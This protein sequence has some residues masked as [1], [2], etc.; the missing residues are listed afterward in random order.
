MDEEDDLSNYEET[1]LGPLQELLNQNDTPL[2]RSYNPG[3][4]TDTINFLDSEWAKTSFLVSDSSLAGGDT[5]TA[6]PS[7]KDDIANR[8]WSSAGHKFTDTR[9]GGNTAV[10]ARPQ[11]NRYADIRN[12]GRLANR[13]DVTVTSM[14][15]N[16]G[17]G[18][19][20]SEAIDDN[21]QTIYMRFGVPQYN[22][23]L[24]FFTNAYNPQ[25]AALVN[26]GQ[27]KGWIYTGGEI[28]GTVF[29]VVAFPVLSAAVLGTR[30]ISKFFTRATSKFYTMKPTMFLYWSA[31]DMLVNAL[32][33]NRGLMPKFP[34][35]NIE[36]QRIGDPFKYDADFINDLHRLAPHIFNEQGRVDV[37]AVA[38]RA[39]RIANQVFLQEYEALDSGDAT[40]FV[41]YVNNGRGKGKRTQLITPSGDKPLTAILAEAA[42][43]QKWFNLPEDADATTVSSSSPKI[44]PL[45][46]QQLSE[47]NEDQSS[48]DEGWAESFVK[49]LDAELSQGGAFAVFKVNYTGSMNESFSNAI[50][51]SDLSQ[52]LN[53]AASTARQLRFSFAEGNVGSG[54]IAEFI[55]SAL[56]GVKDLVSGALSGLTLNLSDGIMAALTGSYYD[57]PKTWQS[58]SASLPRANYT[59][60]LVTPYGHPLAQ[61]QNIYIPFCMLLA[62]VLPRSTGKQTYTSP[63]LCQIYDRGR[64]QIQLGMVESL[65]VTRATTNLGFTRKGQANGITVNFSVADLSSIMHMPMGTGTIWEFIKSTVGTS[66]SP[67]MDEDNILMDYLAVIAGLDLYNQLYPLPRARLQAARMYMQAAKYSSPALW[68]AAVHDSITSGVLSYTPVGWIGNAI[69]SMAPG[70]SIITSER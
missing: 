24:S 36:T 12:K 15:G 69:E 2:V 54:P 37:Y 41:G 28:L 68:A 70:S 32:V 38:L 34:G 52:K 57:F 27:A 7:V 66:Q 18:R 64:C 63:F 43:V 45:T 50:M 9:L 65:S 16:Y 14:S 30:F 25:M 44:D 21:A 6:D 59:V 19:Y 48:Q 42:K 51:E 55:Q 5:S 13:S 35:G 10:N 11:F 26:T 47:L 4:M 39:Q 58:A 53:Q 61:L 17:M 22:S 29:T 62:A 23:L 8:Y 31:V 60:Q 1:D 3:A 33:V 20:Y 67:I 46:G 40:S 49:Y 56:G